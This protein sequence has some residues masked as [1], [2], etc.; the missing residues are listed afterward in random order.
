MGV[1]DVLEIARLFFVQKLIVF[2]HFYLCE[3][4]LYVRCVFEASKTPR[5]GAFCHEALTSGIFN[6][7][8]YLVLLLLL[9]SHE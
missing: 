4:F 5:C 8:Y 3:I 1:A 2:N 6:V 9:Y 7:Q